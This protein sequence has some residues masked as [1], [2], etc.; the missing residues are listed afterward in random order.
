[1]SSFIYLFLKF[2]FGLIKC[3][4]GLVYEFWLIC[5]IL[6]TCEHPYDLLLNLIFWYVNS[7][8]LSN[9]WKIYIIKSIFNCFEP[10]SKIYKS[11]ECVKLKYLIHQFSKKNNKIKLIDSLIIYCH[12]SRRYRYSWAEKISSLFN[13]HANCHELVPPEFFIYFISFE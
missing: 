7:F 5:S 9:S 1:M 10:V 12:R 6:E 3:D 8:I 11:I 13:A 4:S 2:W